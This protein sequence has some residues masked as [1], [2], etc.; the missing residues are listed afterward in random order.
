MNPDRPAT[1]ELSTRSGFGLRVRPVVAEDEAALGAFFGQVSPDDLRFRFL[2]AVKEVSHERLL[3][4]INVDRSRTDSFLATGTGVGD[5]VIAAA[6]L[7]RDATGDQAEV[8]ISVRADHKG[9]GIGWTLLEYCAREA[10]AKG[11]KVLEAVESRANHQAIALE[12]EM[13]FT[14]EPMEGDPSVALLRRS[15]V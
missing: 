9:R 4:M 11:V 6:M 7:A 3:A 5:P 10:E 1:S 14:S 8:A 15:L 13:G 2:T 12:H